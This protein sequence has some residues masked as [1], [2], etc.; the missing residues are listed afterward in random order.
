MQAIYHN[1]LNNSNREFSCQINYLGFNLNFAWKY[2]W[3]TMPTHADT[4]CL[5]GLYFLK[6]NKICRNQTFIYSFCTSWH[7]PSL[8]T[9][10]FKWIQRIYKSHIIAILCHNLKDIL[11]QNTS[12][13][14]RY[15]YLL[16]LVNVFSEYTNMTA[17][18]K[19]VQIISCRKSISRI[20]IVIA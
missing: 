2:G 10:S 20:M 1:I 13:L 17:K 11:V 19:N 15:L 14:W 3:N 6:Q 18:T 12:L 4:I 7:G 8:R 9:W 5:E 16:L